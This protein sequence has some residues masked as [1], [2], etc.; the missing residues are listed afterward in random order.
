[1]DDPRLKR[2]ALGFLKAADPP[3]P[4]EL[5]AFYARHYY[6]AERGNYRKSYSPAEIDWINLKIAQKAALLERLRGGRPPGS[7]LDAGCGEGFGLAWFRERGWRVEGIDHSTA[8]ISRMNPDLLPFVETGNLFAR[9]EERIANGR[10][11]DLVWLTHV[12][13]HVADPVALLRLLRGLVADEGVL[14]VTVPNDGSA[15]QEMLLEDGDVPDRYWVA[16]PDHLAYF[17]RDSLQRTVQATGWECRSILGDFPIDVFLL[18]E[19]S[20][21][22]RDREKGP[23]AHAARL[24]M[25]LLL[26]RLDHASVNAFYEAMA[27]VGLGRNLTAFLTPS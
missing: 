3:S 19:G 17:D 13:E 1:M 26:G 18:H 15:L 12:L 25:E 8:G 9:L 10:K 14:V 2:D 16:L 27:R 20:N 5:A 21:Y 24:R 4:D 22:V 11:Y 6:Q 23:A 7:M